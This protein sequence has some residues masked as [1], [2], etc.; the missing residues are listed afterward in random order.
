MV[1]AVVFCEVVKCEILWDIL[2]IL[3]LVN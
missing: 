2:N 3:P 1:N